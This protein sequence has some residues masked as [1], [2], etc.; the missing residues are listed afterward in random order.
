M[1]ATGLVGRVS[2]TGLAK[3]KGVT[4]GLQVTREC[5][6]EEMRRRICQ[7]GIKTRVTKLIMHKPDNHRL[8]GDCD[9][10]KAIFPQQTISVAPHGRGGVT[11][12]LKVA[13]ELSVR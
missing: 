10:K 2:L 9:A 8:A 4:V 13:R 11:E 7:S 1:L 12:V 3:I 5:A 6:P